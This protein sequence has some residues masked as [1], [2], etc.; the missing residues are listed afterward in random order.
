MLGQ[1]QATATTT[2]IVPIAPETTENTGPNAPAT[3]PDSKPPSRFDVPM[4]R[5]V[6]EPTRPRISSG[7]TSGAIVLRITTLTMSRPPM[8][9][10]MA[11]DSVN[12]RDTPKISVPAPNPRTAH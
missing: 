3:A 1:Y 8:T 4:N 5:P 11:I 10:S 2:T 7:V 12:D 9:T 6:I